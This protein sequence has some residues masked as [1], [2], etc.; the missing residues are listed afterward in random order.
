MDGSL[1]PDWFYHRTNT[2]RTSE[3]RTALNSKQWTLISS[4]R[5]LADTKITSENGQQSYIHACQPLS[6]RHRCW[7]QRSSTIVALLRIVLAFLVTIKQRRG[8]KMQPHRVQQS[9]ITTPTESIRNAY[10]GYLRVP[11]P[12]HSHGISVALAI[13]LLKRTIKMKQNIIH[14]RIIFRF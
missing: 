14:L 9:Q 13:L 2:F 3:K 10:N 7:I 8:P 5:T 6:L 12:H 1:A 11:G 4:Q